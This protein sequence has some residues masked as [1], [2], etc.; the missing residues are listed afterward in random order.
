MAYFGS[1]ERVR[2]QLQQ[3]AS[4]V[5]TATALWAGL[6][7]YIKSPQ[8][9][10][11]EAAV[12]RHLGYDGVCLFDVGTVLDSTDGLG[13]YVRAVSGSRGARVSRL[14]V[15]PPRTRTRGGGWLGTIA[16]RAA[17]GELPPLGDIGGLLDQRWAE[18]EAAQPVL[19][20]TRRSLAAAVR[21]LPA[22]LDLVGV[23]RYVHPGDGAQRRD[24]QRGLAEQSRQRLLA[25]EDPAVVV[26][27]LSQGGTRKLGG[28][29]PRRY[30]WSGDP[31]AQ[32]LRGLDEGDV[33]AVV[34]VAN[35][36]WVY[37]VV[38]RE[39]PRAVAVAE[40]PWPA[41][42]QWFREALAVALGEVEAADII[43][44][45]GQARIGAE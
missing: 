16:T 37:R 1:E 25:G 17:G 43:A 18:F 14:P 40:A 13:G 5:G 9:L 12:A 23:F 4:V 41:R 15:A 44:E 33:S 10:R 34:T 7:A 32:Q 35:G 24:A 27:E 38:R 39:P 30:L 8:E 2:G 6:G 28:V 29:L 21:L 22:A 42:R 31:V 26:A 3:A 11:G 20:E 36:F 45:A 19:A